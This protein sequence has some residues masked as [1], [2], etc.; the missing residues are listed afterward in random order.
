M[1]K[2]DM[3]GY[4]KYATVD[5][6]KKYWRECLALSALTVVAETGYYAWYFRNDIKLWIETKS[7]ENKK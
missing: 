4:F 5:L 6:W 7:K 1:K 3:V 2:L